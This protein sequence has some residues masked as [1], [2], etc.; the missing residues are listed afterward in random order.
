MLM[1]EM[2]GESRANL[3]RKLF[4]KHEVGDILWLFPSVFFFIAM[5]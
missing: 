4:L 3:F 5:W 1:L 2:E